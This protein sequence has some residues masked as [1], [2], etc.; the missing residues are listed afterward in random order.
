MSYILE[1]REGVNPLC[2]KLCYAWSHLFDPEEL[3]FLARPSLK[4][5]FGFLVHNPKDEKVSFLVA[6]F[7]HWKVGVVA[8]NGDES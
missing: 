4:L 1:G 5:D 6:G 2:H 3:A 8:R 7:I